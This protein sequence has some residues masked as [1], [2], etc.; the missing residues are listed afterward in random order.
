MK[1]EVIVLDGFLNFEVFFLER[2]ERGSKDV[3]IELLGR[4]KENRQEGEMLG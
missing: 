2:C 3:M 4:Y 1:W